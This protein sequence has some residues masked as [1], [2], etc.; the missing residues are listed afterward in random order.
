MQPTEGH[1]LS[2]MIG[3]ISMRKPT[4]INGVDINL[5]DRID[6]YKTRMKHIKKMV[7]MPSKTIFINHAADP[8]AKVIKICFDDD[9]ILKM[10]M[11]VD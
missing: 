11:D 7:H 8:D 1:S 9:D 4:Y 5:F 3:G 2:G 6:V 10:L